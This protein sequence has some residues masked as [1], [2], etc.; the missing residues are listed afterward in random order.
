MGET[1]NQKKCC[2]LVVS[3]LEKI[4]GETGRNQYA[5]DERVPDKLT[6]DW[7]VELGEL[8]YWIEH[9]RLEPYKN[10]IRGDKKYSRLVEYLK[11]SDY[12]PLPHDMAVSIGISHRVHRVPGRD[13]STYAK[14]V[15]YAINQHIRTLGTITRDDKFRATHLDVD[16]IDIVFSPASNTANAGEISF[17]RTTPPRLDELRLARLERTLAKK[18]RK[19]EQLKEPPHKTVIVLEFSDV[20]ASDQTTIIDKIDILHAN[21]A[22][23]PDELFLIN[24]ASTPWMTWHLISNRQLREN[25]RVQ[26]EP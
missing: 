9:T 4:T 3:Y 12:R 10:A 16:G 8:H 1:P 6:T 14:R 22:Q 21:G 24:T 20:A 17:S 2:T 23:F 13:I 7:H 11:M 25:R 19:F 18:S 5:P 15:A 26:I